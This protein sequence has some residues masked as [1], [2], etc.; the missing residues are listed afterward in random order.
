[1]K[2]VYYEAHGG[3]EVLKLGDLP[4]PGPGPGEVLVQVAA[5]AVN[6]IDRRLRA[7]ELQE[8]ITR[9]FPVVPGWDMAG[10]IVKV[11]ADV[12][13][14]QVG[15][16]ILGLAFTWSIQ[17]GSYAEY[18]PISASSIAAKPAGMSFVE[19][20]SLPLVTLTAW[21][22]LKEFADLKPGQTVLIQAGA[23]GVGSV[24]IPI[25]KHLG[26]T[27]YTTASARNAD[28]VRGLGAD[29]VIDYTSTD[30]VSELHK[31]EPGGLDAVLETILS[32]ATIE[33]AIHLVKPGG[34][35]AYMNNEPPP[36]PEIKEKNIKTA[37]IHHRPDGQSLR[38]LMPLFEQGIL[39]IPDIE[40][41]PL[42]EAQAAHVKSESGRTRGKIV[43]K[44]QDIS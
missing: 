14:C 21:Q 2:A 44:V 31:L 33:A 41:M 42:E 32:D 28:Y 10:R 36:M 35:V 25:A 23:G 13:G 43:L 5:A 22:S 16:D 37:F 38:E 26:A 1:M 4:V 7:G 11:G 29:H 17:H 3:P 34:T 8:Y 24:A 9:T 39:K 6:P 18:A 20:A 19:A 40:V 12:T 30:Y 27:V 15:D